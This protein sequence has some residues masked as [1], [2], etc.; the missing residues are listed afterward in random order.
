[1]K[2]RLFSIMICINSFAFFLISFCHNDDYILA[3]LALSNIIVWCIVYSDNKK[4]RSKY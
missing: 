2:D 4:E 1:M 3:I